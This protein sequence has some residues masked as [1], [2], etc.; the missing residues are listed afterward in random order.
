[1]NPKETQMS[2]IASK[3]TWIISRIVWTIGTV[4]TFL[5]V[6]GIVL[7]IAGVQPPQ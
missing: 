3:I 7:Q 1:M 5:I 2:A 4:F 6:L